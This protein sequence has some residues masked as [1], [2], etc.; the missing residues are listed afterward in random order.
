MSDIVQMR[1]EALQSHT[2]QEA[3]RHS[4]RLGRKA[5]DAS[6]RSWKLDEAMRFVR[7][8]QAEWEIKEGLAR[9]AALIASYDDE[10]RRREVLPSCQPRGVDRRQHG[11][12]R[13][14]GAGLGRHVAKLPADPFHPRPVCVPG[15]IRGTAVRSGKAAP[16][17]QRSGCFHEVLCP[18]GCRSAPDLFRRRV[19]RPEP[20]RTPATA[21]H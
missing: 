20:D 21:G 13:S 4:R 6:D 3:Q 19:V 18:A 17:H 15:R 2:F 16:A 8:A 12:R 14:R 10:L 5:T 7:H 11:R 9:L 1:A